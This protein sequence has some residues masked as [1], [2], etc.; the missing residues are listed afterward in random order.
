MEVRVR[1]PTPL[2]ELV[3]GAS[4]VAVE[5]L[6]PTVTI[7]DVLD[8]LATAHPALERRV[9]DEQGRARAHVNVFVGQDNI[10]DR[11]GPA[12]VIGP[13]EDVSILPAISGG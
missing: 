2:R 9:R 1:V 13:G 10:R 4:T 12:T 8:G 11:H 7:A 3:G 5:M 6:G